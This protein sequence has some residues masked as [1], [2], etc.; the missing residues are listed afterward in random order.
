[1]NEHSLG[2]TPVAPRP[3]GIGYDCCA[4][5]DWEDDDVS[6]R[7]FCRSCGKTEVQA[8]KEIART[9]PHNAQ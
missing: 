9:K 8:E 7:C 3:T 6:G 4:R 2:G 1:M 5:P